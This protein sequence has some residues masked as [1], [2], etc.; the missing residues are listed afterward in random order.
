[1]E[2]TGLSQVFLPAFVS[3]YTLMPQSVAISSYDPEYKISV[4]GP[5]ARAVRGS[6]QLVP[7][8]DH[9]QQLARF[10]GAAVRAYYSSCL[11]LYAF[12]FSGS[13]GSKRLLG[14]VPATSRRARRGSFRRDA[15]DSAAQSPCVVVH[16]AGCGCRDD[17]YPKTPR[18]IRP[19]HDDSHAAIGKT[20]SH[21]R[22][23][24]PPTCW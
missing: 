18:A 2:G 3:R 17:S 13:M 20:T 22:N 8:R 21:L 4:G 12:S 23:S 6:C 11:R 7:S 16:W 24:L 9:T 1:M 14:F 19:T 10:Q 5:S 15:L